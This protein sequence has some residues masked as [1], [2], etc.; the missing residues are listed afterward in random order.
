MEKEAFLK[1][2]KSDIESLL[3]EYKLNNH[4]SQ[5][6]AWK[7][8]AS[9]NRSFSEQYLFNRALFLSTNSCFLLENKF[10][11]KLAIKGLYESAEIYEY[12]SELADISNFYDKEFL[13]ILSALC[14]DLSGYQ[15]NAFCVANR[16]QSYELTGSEIDLSVDNIIIEQI[17][18]ILLKKIPLAVNKLN[19]NSILDKDVGYSL[20]RKGIE[21]WYQYLLRLID[22]DYVT[23]LSQVYLYFLNTNNTYLSHLLFLLKSRILV[24]NERGIWTVLKEN[25]RVSDS[26]KWRK[27]IKLLAFDYYSNNSIKEINER[28]SIFELWTSQIR[29]IEQ[30]LI[31][32]DE[33]FVVQMPT[34]AGKTF[35]AELAILKHLIQNPDKK[36]IYVAPFRALTSEKELELSKYFS[37]IGFSVSSLT[38]SYEIDEFQD[39]ILSE[40]DLLIATPEKIDLLL[41]LNPNFFDMVSFVVVDEGHIIGNYDTR[42]T[43]LEFLIIRLRIKIPGLKTLFISAVMPPKNANEYASWLSGKETNVLR[44]LKFSDS[45]V[46]EEWEPTRKLIGQ[47]IWDGENGKIIFKN[48]N[49]EDEKTKKRQDA[50]IPYYLEEKQYGDKFPKIGNK[51]ETTAALAYKLSFEG[52]TLIFCAQ[53]RHTEWIYKRLVQIIDSEI[54]NNIPNWFITNENKI[55]VYYS[56]IWFGENHYITKALKQGIGVH[57]GDMPEQV[58]NSVEHDYREGNLRI[59]LSSNTIGQGLNFPIKNLIFYSIQLDQGKHIDKRDFWNIVGRAGR[60]GKETEGMI[61]FVVNSY[62]DS[63]LFKDFSNK[64]NIE[65]AD[66][67]VF[68]ALNTLNQG[69]LSSSSF[70]E[71]L[72]ILS[73]T[74]L[75]DLLSE[76]ILGTEYE[77]IIEKIIKNSLFKIQIDNRKIDDTPIKDGFKKIF[78]SFEKDVSFEQLSKFRITGFSFKSNKIIDEYIDNHFDELKKLTQNDD[79]LG[80]IMSFLEMITVNDLNELYDRKLNS[81]NIRPVNYFEIIEQWIS[82]EHIPNIITYWEKNT[83]RNITDFHIFIS[84]ALYYL[85]PWGLSSF[86]IILAYKIGKE[87]KELPE[88]IKNL[89]SYLKFGLNNPTSCIARSLGIKSRQVSLFLFQRSGLLT[90]N[91]FIIWISNLTPEEIETFEIPF[92]EKENLNDVALK[93]TP[94]SYRSEINTFEFVIKGTFYNDNWAKTSKELQIGEHLNY[95]REELNEFDPYAIIILKGENPIG[96]VPREYSKIIA[97]EIDIED[98]KYEILINK[99]NIKEKH[100][101]VAVTMNV[102]E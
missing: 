77:D 92:Y 82:G 5:A 47:F 1:G 54:E 27:Y 75:L 26:L 94:K 90:G 31:E 78:K 59:L 28:K 2:V 46:E 11:N 101:D 68:K 69:R 83:N 81:F 99:I 56:K 25:K 16:I 96:Y 41:R 91:E 49:T 80:I 85:F 40:T 98:K 72:S 34:S 63:E 57:F 13:T 4:K 60:A 58:R 35:I 6:F 39:V 44:S 55:S 7:L 29:A 17:R 61:V 23:S 71:I 42:A 102:I 38:G 93:L 100:N 21:E 24:Y 20:F 52:N 30:G 89:P 14:Y 79:Y 74:Y 15:A 87:Y 10:D 88:N 50:F 9:F 53:P 32:L 48:V 22:T 19:Q 64:E 8:K 73:E 97:S 51:L 65:E 37:K 33:N 18:L 86:L 84:K 3:G 62:S 45:K 70:S 36:C 76:E 95:A 66:S 43:L 12:L 67:L